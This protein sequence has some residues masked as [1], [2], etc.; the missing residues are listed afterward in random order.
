MPTKK[1]PSRSANQGTRR[2]LLGARYP[3]PHV[4][5]TK[6][7]TTF[8]SLNKSLQVPQ[9]MAARKGCC[10]MKTSKYEGILVDSFEDFTVLSL[11]EM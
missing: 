6:A 7:L 10:C 4:S 1:A 11:K 9:V 8:A 5:N 2:P 3:P